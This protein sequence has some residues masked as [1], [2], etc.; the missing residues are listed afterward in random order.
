MRKRSALLV[1]QGEKPRFYGFSLA[2]GVMLGLLFV[3]KLFVQHRPIQTLLGESMMFVYYGY[4]LPLSTRIARGFYRD[5]IWSDTGF[6]RWAQISAVSWKEEGPVTLVLISHFKNIAR[7][8]EVP[9][10]SLR[11]GTPAAPRPDQGSRDPHRGNGAG[12]GQ[13]GRGGCCLNPEPSTEPKNPC[14]RAPREPIMCVHMPPRPTW[15]G[16]LKVSLVNIPVK[17]FPATESADTIS[18]NQLHAECQ[19]RIQQKRW[20]PALRTR[21]AEHRAGQGLRVREGTLRRRQRRRHPEGPRRIDARHQP[22]AVR[23]RLGDRSDLRRSRVLPRARRSDGRRSVRGDARGDGGEGGH[24]QDGALRP[25][26][27]RRRAPA[28]EGT[29]DVHAASRRRD[30]QHRSDRGAQLRA[31]AR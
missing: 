29:R 7:R 14:T 31:D 12:F 18:F 24:R 22:R 20:C 19:T 8:L 30:P 2:L 13:P 11:T 5:G 27:P 23:R 26:V 4:A 17:V 25:R 15:K 28:E 3:F 16:F 1:W 21:G 10:T 9:G 6:M